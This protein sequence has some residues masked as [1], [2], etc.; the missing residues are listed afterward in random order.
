MNELAL[1][2]IELDAFC[3]EVSTEDNEYL[4]E[5]MERGKETI[6]LDILNQYVQA[7]RLRHELVMKYSWAIPN[8]EAIEAI[9]SLGR[10]IVEIG[11]GYGYWAKLISEAGG[12][13]KCFDEVPRNIHLSSLPTWYN[14]EAGGPEKAA[15][16]TDHALM[17]CWPPYNESMAADALRCYSGEYL[18]YVGES[19]GGCTGDNNFHEMLIAGWEKIDD[20]S[21]PQWPRIHDYLVIYKRR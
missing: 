18:I 6:T 15:E 9:V 4:S 16:N 7:Y 13:I 5:I 17:L 2:Q 14:V 19:Y 3:P 12:K 10:P 20:I 11:A 8:R 1:T 21:I